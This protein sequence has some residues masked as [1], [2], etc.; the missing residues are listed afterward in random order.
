MLMKLRRL[1]VL[2]VFPL[3]ALTINCGSSGK[4]TPVAPTTSAA[5]RP[6]TVD[7]ISVSPSG[8]GM[9]GITGFTFS[10]QN[11]QD[12]DG[13]EL[14]STWSF[15]DGSTAMGATVTHT[16][17]N[18]GAFNVGVSVSDGKASAA[19]P[20]ISVTVAANLTSPIWGT[21]ASP[22]QQCGPGG[23]ACLPLPSYPQMVL[24]LQQDGS[25]LSGTLALNRTCNGAFSAPISLKGTVNSLSYPAVVEF[26]TGTFVCGGNSLQPTMF[27]SLQANATGTALSGTTKQVLVVPCSAMP[28]GATCVEPLPGPITFERCVSGTPA[29]ATVCSTVRG[30]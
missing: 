17:S 25:T 26:T 5:N 1:V 14:T 15:G 19:A 4:S 2:P 23:P 24:S 6:P 30:S 18:A 10:A 3:A 28:P 21:A 29:S 22:S 16:Y 9:A 27:F 8:T 13:T 12:P 11:A 20:A 7:S